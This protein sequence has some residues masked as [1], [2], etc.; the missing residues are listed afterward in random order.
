MPS[1]RA[2]WLNAQNEKLAVAES[3]LSDPGENEILIKTVSYY[4][5]HP[6]VA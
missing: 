1:N 6:H 2:A 5:Q 3:P 4:P